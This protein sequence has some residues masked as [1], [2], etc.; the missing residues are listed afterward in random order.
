MVG[1]AP[2]RAHRRLPPNGTYCWLGGR[3]SVLR[4]WRRC[5]SLRIECTAFRKSFL[6]SGELQIGQRHKNFKNNILE[7]G[8][9]FDVVSLQFTYFEY[10]CTVFEKKKKEKHTCSTTGRFSLVFL[11]IRILYELSHTLPYPQSLRGGR[12]EG[13]REV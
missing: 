7:K 6:L 4:S 1:R 12:E 5:F 3:D 13:R 9:L 8:L 11:Q 2:L 10:M